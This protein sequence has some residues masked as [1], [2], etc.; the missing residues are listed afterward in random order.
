V[1]NVAT[2]RPRC[3]IHGAIFRELEGVFMNKDDIAEQ[4][5]DLIFSGDY[6]LDDLQNIIGVG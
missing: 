5:N 3:D 6:D 4:L 2:I 1:G